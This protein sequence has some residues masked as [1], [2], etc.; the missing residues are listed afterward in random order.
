V[1]NVEGDLTDVA[2]DRLR[3]AGLNVSLSGEEDPTCNNL[4][5]VI[6]QNPTGGTVVPRGTTVSIVVG[7]RPAPPRECP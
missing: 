2:I 6:R 5:Q 4:G 7:E 1:P 3:D